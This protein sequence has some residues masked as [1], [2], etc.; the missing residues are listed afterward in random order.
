VIHFTCSKCAQA[1]DAPESIRGESMECP[2]CGN[3]QKVTGENPDLMKPL[4]NVEPICPYCNKPLI[5]KPKRRSKC[6]H[7]GNFFR[8]RTRPQDRQQ[9]LVTEEQAEEIARQYYL[10]YGRDPENWLRE[11]RI[12]WDQQWSELN[13]QSGKYAKDGQWGLYRNCRYAMGDIF[14]AEANFL[15][16]V[17]KYSKEEQQGIQALSMKQAIR[18]YLEVALFDLNGASNHNE[19]KLCETKIQFWDIAPAV[20]D[21][22]VELSTNLGIQ[23]NELRELFDEVADQYTGFPFP[24]TTND[25]W[26]RFG[27]ALTE[28]DAMVAAD[29]GDE[30]GGIE[31]DEEKGTMA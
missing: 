29:G 13:K 14:Q 15:V 3:L 17:M 18:M 7:C 24:L 27:E 1:M 20:M 28:Y 25:A 4:G 26:K 10:G 6:P 19:F 11:K 22:I 5:K 21:W 12:V 31:E 30:D 16:T 9:V 23:R 8:V 2:S